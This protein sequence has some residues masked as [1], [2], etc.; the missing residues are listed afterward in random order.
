MLVE[1]SLRAVALLEGLG[2]PIVDVGSGG[3]APG[4]PL[5]LALPDREFV[6]LE[7]QRR[8]CAFLEHWAPFER[9]RRLRSRRGAGD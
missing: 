1:D 6:L 8:K 5:A 2:D 7:S 3:G 9:A 4:I